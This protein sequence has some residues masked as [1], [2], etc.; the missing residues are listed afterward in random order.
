MKITYLGTGSAFCMNNFQTNALIENNGQK[1][2]IDAGSDIRFSLAEQKLTANDLDAVYISHQHA[3]HIG[4]VE[5]IAFVTY[6][7]PNK[8]PITLY[9]NQFLVKDMWIETLCGGLKSIQGKCMGLSDYFKVQPVACNQPFWWQ[10]IEFIPVQTVHVM[11]GYKIVS[12]F[13]L[14]VRYH[15]ETIFMTTDTQFAPSQ[16][17]D[18]YKQATLIFHDCETTPFASGVHAHYNQLSTLDE[19]TKE[20]MWLTHYQDG[21]LPDAEADGF[22]GFVK[23]GQVFKF[24]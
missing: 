19:Q 7:M 5:Y 11:D 10:N 16:L 13:G 17:L 21:E 14:M 3:D 12:S 8:E 18:F 15:G 22:K 24:E 9:A 1:L 23:K 2:L 4:G 6:F 20:K